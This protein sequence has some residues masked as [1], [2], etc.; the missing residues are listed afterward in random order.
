[1][2]GIA[3]A[4]LIVTINHASF[5]FYLW[6]IVAGVEVF[7]YS[8]IGFFMTEGKHE[9]IYG[10]CSIAAAACVIVQLGLNF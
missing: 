4:W 6:P 5:G 7:V 1:M 10:I 2:I 8:T 9:L 3:F